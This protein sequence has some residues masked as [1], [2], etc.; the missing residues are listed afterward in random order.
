MK[1]H[2]KVKPPKPVKLPF[3]TRLK[4]FFPT[5]KNQFW[6]QL[7]VIPGIVWLIVFCYVPMYGIIIAFENY[8]PG[9]PFLNGKFVGLEHFITFFQDKYALQSVVNT[10]KIS[11]IKLVVGFPA[12]IIFA[13]LLNELTSEKFKKFVQSVSYLPFFISWVVMWGILYSLLN[14]N[15]P[16]NAL[17]IMLGINDE[18]IAFL[19]KVDAFIP[20]AVLSDLWKGVGWS[21]ILYLAAISNVPQDMYEAAYIDGANRFQRCMKITFPSILPTVTIMLI[22]SVSG[23]LGSNFDQHILLANANNIS[24]AR[25][26]DLYVYQMGIQSGRYSY[27]TAV[28]LSRSIISFVLLISADRLARWVSD[29][30]RGLF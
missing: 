11:L 16:L 19:A 30:E 5:L 28:N 25:T 13:L 22:L 20:I 23:I 4:R 26:I 2:S 3:K 10:L 8:K 18:R 12:P 15:G 1:K 24:V 21:S 29:G 17:L 9:Q 7:M 27:S 14:L 6:L